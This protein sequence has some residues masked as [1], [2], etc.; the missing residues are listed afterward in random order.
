MRLGQISS[1]H[2]VSNLFAS[3]LGFVATVYIAR[4]LGAEPLGTYHLSLGL[5]S[6]LSIVGTMGFSE[7]ISKRI[8]EGEEQGAY[9]VAGVSIVAGFFVIVAI[10]LVVAREYVNAYVGFSVTGF[11]ILILLA[12]LGFSVVS[13]I[14]RGLSLVHIYGILMPI[15]VGARSFLQILLIIAG[16]SVT[17]L[18]I[19]HAAGIILV[20]VVGSYVVLRNLPTLTRPKRRHFKNLI[21]FAK[22]SWLGDIRGRMFNYM[23]VII[24]GFFVSQALIGIYSV[25]WSVSQF[26]AI[27]SGSITNTLFPEMSRLSSEEDPSAVSGLVET[28][29]TYGG[30]FLIPGLFGGTLLGERILRLYGPEFPQ[31]ATVLVILIIANLIQGY[32]QQLLSTLSGIDRPD[33]TFRVNGAFVVANLLLNVGLVYLYGWVGAA[34]A[35]AISAG[36]S[37]VLSYLYV[38]SIIDFSFPSAEI[39]YQVGASIIMGC[40]VYGGIRFGEEFMLLQNNTILVTIIII[41]GAST[42]FVSLTILSAE[43]RKTIARNLPLGSLGSF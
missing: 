9:A 25:A 22:Y 30:L 14:L 12:V 32:Q 41:V 37:Y 11:L 26:L 31:G 23:D 39:A 3:V 6:W 5:V 19:G 20:V 10:F 40:V 24:L 16:F 21:E 4:I 15:K 7:A 34:V 13:N 43:F 35:T 28:S 38:R 27:F 17:G 42:Y 33:L 1:I 18:F 8:S 29:L 36:I 2:F